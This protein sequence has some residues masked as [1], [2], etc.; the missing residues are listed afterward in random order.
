MH[1]PGYAITFFELVLH[2]SRLNTHSF[3]YVFPSDPQT[4]EWA[5]GQMPLLKHSAEE[6]NLDLGILYTYIKDPIIYLI[7]GRSPSRHRWRF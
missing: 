7:E 1:S 2:I 5:R 4:G 6:K 3:G